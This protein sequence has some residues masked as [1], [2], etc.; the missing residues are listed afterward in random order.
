MKINLNYG[1]KTEIGHEAPMPQEVTFDYISSAINQKYQKGL[2]GAE[3][4]LWARVQR[5][6]DTA[7]EENAE[8]V[9]LE[10]AEQD[11]IRIAFN[12]ALYPPHLARLV[13]VLEDEIE[14]WKKV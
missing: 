12:A 13:Q 1:I 8:T 14:S 5:K 9:E 3:R 11:F 7:I 4:R 10:A 6:F 2:A